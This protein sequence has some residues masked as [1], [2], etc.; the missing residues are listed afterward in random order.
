MVFPARCSNVL[1]VGAKGPRRRRIWEAVSKRFGDTLPE[2]LRTEPKPAGGYAGYALMDI[3]M[4]ALDK[5][6]DAHHDVLRTVIYYAAAAHCDVGAEAV[7]V[8]LNRL[9]ECELAFLDRWRASCRTEF[10]K[11][12]K[13]E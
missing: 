1:I 3:A 9:N 8:D 10:Q 13:L 11:F 2:D 6:E 12:T 7:W 5:C 4:I